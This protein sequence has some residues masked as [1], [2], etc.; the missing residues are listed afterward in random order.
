MTEARHPDFQTNGLL[1]VLHVSADLPHAPAE[2]PIERVNQFNV[3]GV[4]FRRATGNAS[5]SGG[6]IDELTL[7]LASGEIQTDLPALFQTQV[8]PGPV[9]HAVA[10]LFALALRSFLQPGFVRHGNHPFVS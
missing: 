9:R 3:G 8:I 5:C 10:R 4:I 7:Q 6:R 2:H 1:V